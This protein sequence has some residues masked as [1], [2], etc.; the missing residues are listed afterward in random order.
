MAE[1]SGMVPYVLDSGDEISISIRYHVQ[2]ENRLITGGY[3]TD[4][5][6]NIIFSPLLHRDELNPR[7]VMVRVPDGRM[8][9]TYVKTLSKFLELRANPNLG[10]GEII[11]AYG[12]N[13]F[14][15]ELSL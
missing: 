6:A 5:V 14:R 13:L 2:P 12:E 10:W 8:L 15:L 7:V 1:V 4:D 9:K 11:R 3:A